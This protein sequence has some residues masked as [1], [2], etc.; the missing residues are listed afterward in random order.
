MAKSKINI[1]SFLVVSFAV[2]HVFSIKS[3]SVKI[4]RIGQK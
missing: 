1:Q 2:Y 4:V 3:S